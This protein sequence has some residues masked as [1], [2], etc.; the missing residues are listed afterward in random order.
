[1][2]GQWAGPP[3]ES[4]RGSL[5][6]DAWSCMK[7]KEAAG[8]CT[9]STVKTFRT[10]FTLYLVTLYFCVKCVV[11][12]PNKFPLADPQVRFPG[13]DSRGTTV[14][15]NANGKWLSF[16]RHRIIT[17]ECCN[18]ILNLIITWSWNTQNMQG[19]LYK[20]LIVES[21]SDVRNWMYG[22]VSGIRPGVRTCVYVYAHI[23]TL[24]IYIYIYIYMPVFLNRR[25][26]ARYRA[27]ASIIPGRERFYWNLSF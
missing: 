1:V 14:H 5:L 22:I 6:W 15:R 11:D 16:A 23:Y 2:I 12:Y 7:W 24:Y 10:V 9:S 13:T 25:A 8:P 18:I 27:L 21:Y 17:H 20:F 26:A 19:A 3:E 4:L